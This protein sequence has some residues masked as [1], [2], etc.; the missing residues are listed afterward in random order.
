MYRCNAH[1][2]FGFFR[3][4]AVGLVMT[5]VLTQLFLFSFYLNGLATRSAASIQ[6]VQP[7]EVELEVATVPEI[8]IE[9]PVQQTGIP[10][11]QPPARGLNT[12][13]EK[14]SGLLMH[15]PAGAKS[16]AAAV[17]DAAKKALDQLMTN[18]SALDL[19]AMAAKKLSQS[20][21]NQSN[22]RRSSA[23][24]SDTVDATTP[25]PSIKTVD[26]INSSNNKGQYGQLA[27]MGLQLLANNLDP[28]KA[29]AAAQFMLLNAAKSDAGSQMG[30]A[31]LT[32]LLSGAMGGNTKLDPKFMLAIASK[33]MQQQ[34]QQPQ[35]R[36][37]VADA[38]NN[39]GLNLF[40]QLLNNAP[41]ASA[42]LNN[43]MGGATVDPSLTIY[44]NYVELTSP[45]NSKLPN[46]RKFKVN[47]A[48]PNPSGKIRPPGKKV[49]NVDFKFPIAES[50]TC[51]KSG[52]VTY[53]VMVTSSAERFQ[54]R[55]SVRDTWMRDFKTTLDEKSSRKIRI[56]FV[57]GRS[58]NESISQSLIEESQKF[59]DVIQADVPAATPNSATLMTL[60]A[61]AW[62]SR[63]CADIKQM[64]KCD[65]DV[66]V[67]PSKL[68]KMME[69]KRYGAGPASVVGRIISRMNPHNTTDERHSLFK[70]SWPLNE[71]PRFVMGGAYLIG[72]QALPRLLSAAQATPL[73]PIEDVYVTGLCAIASKVDLIQSKSLFEEE[74]TNDLDICSFEDY[75]TWRTTSVLDMRQTWKFAQTIRQSGQICI[76][77]KC[78]RTF[79]G[80]CIPS[81]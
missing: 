81:S 53:L 52:S 79:L 25:A 27:Q 20:Q 34:Q 35:Q 2:G 14:L 51:T 64:V 55:Q 22:G 43:A 62:A 70:D 36:G 26:N 23:D 24:V 1:Y 11:L 72:N 29:S 76:K 77:P 41:L 3:N 49:V 31:A 46:L 54:E 45:K 33:L 5:L 50:G 40:T 57:V 16:S 78:Q 58:V 60:A 63:F 9:K 47:S 75:A 6:L 13:G 56:R 42:L 17:G 32:A 44:R 12:I 8:K 74:L 61:L 80:V 21:S 69:D 73:L 37:S 18:R 66:F 68:I 4:R 67:N 71:F 39:V 7:L 48:Y 38:T 30:R 10:E 28:A 15:P 59:G 65:D 19:V